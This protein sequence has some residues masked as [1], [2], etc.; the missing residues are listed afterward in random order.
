MERVLSISQPQITP[1]R[2]GL[3]PIHTAVNRVRV[4]LFGCWH[5]RM[6]WPITRDRQTYRVCLRC[7]MC[8]SFD[9]KT[10]KTFGPFYRRD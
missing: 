2:D 10:W 4:S 3:I 9:P 5:R 6:G 1:H 8:R 7:G